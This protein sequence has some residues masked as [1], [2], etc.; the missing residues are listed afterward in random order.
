MHKK[1]LAL[2]RV[3]FWMRP[4]WKFLAAMHPN[5]SFMQCIVMQKLLSRSKLMRGRTFLSDRK[6]N[7]PH[8]ENV[9]FPEFMWTNVA[10]IDFI[11]LQGLLVLEDQMENLKL[12]ACAHLLDPFPLTLSSFC[13]IRVSTTTNT[14]QYIFALKWFWNL[15]NITSGNCLLG[16]QIQP[17]LF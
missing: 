14:F 12:A 2:R 6:L 10:K 17:I 13:F 7:Q 9:Y 16:F 11:F 8:K 1:L 5:R 3:L 15:I 4:G